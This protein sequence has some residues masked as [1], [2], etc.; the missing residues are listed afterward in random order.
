MDRNRLALC[1]CVVFVLSLGATAQAGKKKVN[2]DG[3]NQLKIDRYEAKIVE[4]E[5]ELDDIEETY[6]KVASTLND[7]IKSQ[8]YLSEL[9]KLLSCMQEEPNT[10]VYNLVLPGRVPGPAAVRFGRS[11]SEKQLNETIAAMK[12]DTSEATVTE[13]ATEIVSNKKSFKQ[14][15]KSLYAGE[16]PQ[17]F[18]HERPELYLINGDH[19]KVHSLQ[20]VYH[21]FVLFQDAYRTV[22]RNYTNFSRHMSRLEDS[23]QQNYDGVEIPVEVTKGLK[24]QAR[25]ALYLVQQTAV[26][27]RERAG[28]DGETPLFVFQHINRYNRLQSFMSGTDIEISRPTHRQYEREPFELSDQALELPLFDVFHLDE[29]IRVVNSEIGDYQPEQGS[30]IED[31]VDSF[32]SQLMTAY[33]AKIA[34][35]NEKIETE[36]S[37]GEAIVNSDENTFQR[38]F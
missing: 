18:P 34:E 16:K 36:L 38:Q 7:L 13:C 20:E 8:R 24:E 33:E 30:N 2:R 9:D 15:E 21:T 31:N 6:G 19:Y 23:W 32:V 26:K 1:L 29:T 25:H 14:L 5:S 28:E 37:A 11:K 3:V 10:Y 22:I 35:Y 4:L 17:K 27:I 12:E